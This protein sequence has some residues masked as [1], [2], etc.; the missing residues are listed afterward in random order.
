[1]NL[2]ET[3]TFYW[4]QTSL[5]GQVQVALVGATDGSATPTE[6][7]AGHAVGQDTP[8]KWKRIGDFGAGS[9]LD[10]IEAALPTGRYAVCVRLN[11]RYTTQQFYGGLIG[12]DRRW[13]GNE[14]TY[15]DGVGY[16]TTPVQTLG[17]AA[18]PVVPTALNFS[19]PSTST[20]QAAAST[21][22]CGD[23]AKW[24]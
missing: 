10:E 2:L 23:P 6:C 13:L 3:K 20:K 15:N 1:V 16:L 21:T 12:L 7:N 9:T 8:A 24:S 22:S 14:E 17:F 11:F 19:A 18:A 5:G 4:G